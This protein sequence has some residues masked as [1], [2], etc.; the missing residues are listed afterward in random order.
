VPLTAINGA[1]ENMISLLPAND[2]DA[3]KFLTILQKN[4]RRMNYLVSDL[5]DLAKLEGQERAEMFLDEVNVAEVLKSAI[6]SVSDFAQE[7]NISLDLDLSGISE[8]CS[9]FWER[10][11]VQQAVFNLL[12]NAVKYTPPG[13]GVHLSAREADKSL[14][15]AIT[16][17]GLGIPKEHLSRIFERFYRVDRD[18]SREMGGT[19]LGLSIVKHI[20]EAHRGTVEAQSELGRGSTFTL[21]FPKKA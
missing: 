8:G 3:A 10:D 6:H 18:R 1:L 17:T 7:K 13:G 21:T 20:V 16:D 11:R 2:P 14:V 19:G 12:D 15:I 5:L 4:V 9:L